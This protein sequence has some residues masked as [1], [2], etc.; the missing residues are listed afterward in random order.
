MGLLINGK[1]YADKSAADVKRRSPALAN[2]NDVYR[3]TAE[4][5]KFDRELIQPYLPGGT[6]NPEFIKH[7]PQESKEYGFIKDD[8]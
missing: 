2:Q 1:Y 3:R 7:Y 5:Q 4:Y 6:P 8:K